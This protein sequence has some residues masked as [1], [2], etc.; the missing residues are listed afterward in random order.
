MSSR[1]L[2]PECET[3][4]LDGDKEGKEVLGIAGSDAAPLFE[5]KKCFLDEVALPVQMFV[6][7]A[8]LLS[9]FSWRD[10]RLHALRSRLLND[11]IAVVALVGNQVLRRDASN[12]SLGLA[13]IRPGSF[14]NN[15]SDRHT[16]R[17]HGQIQSVSISLNIGDVAV[18]TRLGALG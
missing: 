13:A 12:E 15:D 3:T 5:R 9:V 7:F 2:E 16:M 4:D 14:C 18:H 11:G 1:D 17:T 10:H 6:I 8:P